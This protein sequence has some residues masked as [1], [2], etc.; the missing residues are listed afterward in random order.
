[1]IAQTRQPLGMG[2]YGVLP[3][4]GGALPLGNCRGGDFDEVGILEQF[5][6]GGEYRRFRLF[7][8][9][10]KLRTRASKLPG[11]SV[12]QHLRAAAAFLIGRAP[13]F[14]HLIST[15]RTC[16]LANRQSG[17]CRDTCERFGSAS[18]LG[19]GG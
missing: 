14:L 7:L 8:M 1:L 13:L 19:A 12:Y 17:R 6:M 16:Y 15:W 9:A 5:G 10:M 11:R 4:E 3:G 18:F 2:L